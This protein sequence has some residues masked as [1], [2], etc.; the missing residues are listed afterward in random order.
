M[1]EKAY[2]LQADMLKALAHPTRLKILELL[3]DGERCV[4][5]IE[6]ALG[7]RQPNISQHLA[8]LRASRLVEA[9]KE[10][11]RMIYRVTDR[12]VFQA[13]DLLTTVSQ[14]QADEVRRAFAAHR[15][16]QA[17]VAA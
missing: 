10:G 1:E 5:E 15:T 3:C 9:R 11:V 14:S 16:T 6:P 2:H 4:C 17:E 12:R 13:L 8:I 7:R